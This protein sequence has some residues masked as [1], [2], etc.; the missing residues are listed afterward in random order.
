MQDTANME[1]LGHNGHFA[2]DQYAAAADPF[3]L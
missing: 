3:G 1:A 2:A